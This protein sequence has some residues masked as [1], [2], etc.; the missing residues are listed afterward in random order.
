MKRNDGDY[1]L[2]KKEKKLAQIILVNFCDRY[3][4]IYYKYLKKKKKYIV[5]YV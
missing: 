2:L 3:K 4:K 1:V 5:N